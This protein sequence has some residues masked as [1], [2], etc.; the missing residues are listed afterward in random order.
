MFKFLLVLEDGD[1]PD[2]AAFV[3]VV[4]GWTVGETFLLTASERF[5]IVG[6]ETEVAPELEGQ[7]IGAIFTVEPA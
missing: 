2:P 6:I 3:T 4:P 1:S 5:R 7:G